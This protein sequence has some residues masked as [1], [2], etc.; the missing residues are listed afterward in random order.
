M[1]NSWRTEPQ[2]LECQIHPGDS[3]VAKSTME[4]RSQQPPVANGTWSWRIAGRFPVMSRWRQPLIA[5][6]TWWWQNTGRSAAMSRSWRL[7]VASA[8]EPRDLCTIPIG[9]RCPDLGV[10]RT[11][12]QHCIRVVR[13]FGQHRIGPSKRQNNLA[14]LRELVMHSLRL[15]HDDVSVAVGRSRHR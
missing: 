13:Q 11:P 14:F 4:F 10:R 2:R 9:G 5:N 7:L 3:N 12:D 1:D 6:G 15:D 8:G